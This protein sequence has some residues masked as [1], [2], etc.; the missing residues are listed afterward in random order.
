[1]NSQVQL[2]G[3]SNLRTVRFGNSSD[4]IVLHNVND[5]PNHFNITA[6]DQDNQIVTIAGTTQLPAGINSTSWQIKHSDSTTA[7]YDGVRENRYYFGAAV[8]EDTAAANQEPSDGPGKTVIRLHYGNTG[9]TSIGTGSAG[10]LVSPVYFQMRNYLIHLYQQEREALG[11]ER[12]ADLDTIY[13]FGNALGTANGNGNRAGYFQLTDES[14]W[15]EKLAGTLW[16]I[17]PDERPLG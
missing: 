9:S 13:G 4:N 10:C 17:R 12:D 11:Q 14:V 6:V 15:N 3:Q 8:T 5:G 16:L 7:I 2:D 1:M